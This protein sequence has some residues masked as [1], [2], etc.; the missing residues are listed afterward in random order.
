[1]EQ[2]TNCNH[3]LE[4]LPEQITTE[5]LEL[6]NFVQENLGLA[7]YWIALQGTIILQRL[8]IYKADEF[9]SV[10]LEH[11]ADTNIMIC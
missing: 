8:T 1:M 11:G 5:F 3:S 6:W 2:K 7:G 4:R 10:L 9:K